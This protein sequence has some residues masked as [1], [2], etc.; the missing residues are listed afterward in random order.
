[1][2]YLFA[3]TAFFVCQFLLAVSLGHA[4]GDS[5]KSLELETP[6]S[7]RY[8]FSYLGTSTKKRPILFL[9]LPAT[10]L[11]LIWSPSTSTTIPK[12]LSY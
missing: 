10:T 9:S 5:S 2:R 7:T 1:M 11:L 8:G 3:A 12:Y 6:D 4:Q